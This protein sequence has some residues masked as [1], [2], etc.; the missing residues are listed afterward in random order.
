MQK[1]GDSTTEGESRASAATIAATPSGGIALWFPR[2]YCTDGVDWDALEEH[3]S[4]VPD[5]AFEVTSSSNSRSNSSL[6]NYE[7]KPGNV[8]A[9]HL[10]V[11]SCNPPAPLSFIQKLLDAN[12]D[13]LHQTEGSSGWNA[14]H[15][16][17]RFNREIDV[18]LVKLLI[19]AKPDL[20]T[21]VATAVEDFGLPPLAYAKSPEVVPMLIRAMP[22]NLVSS[23]LK[24]VF[25]KR[26]L[27]GGS[28]EA[29]EQ[30][31]RELSAIELQQGRSILASGIL[32]QKIARK[33]S[34][35]EYALYQVAKR[36]QGSDEWHDLLQLSSCIIRATYCLSFHKD[37]DDNA[38]NSSPPA[39]ECLTI[40][41]T[42]Q[43]IKRQALELYQ[44]LQQNQQKYRE[45]TDCMEPGH[46][47]LARPIDSSLGEPET[48]PTS[49]MP[50]H[51]RR[52]AAEVE[53]L[54]LVEEKKEEETKGLIVS[55]N[56]EKLLKCKQELD[57]KIDKSFDVLRQTAASLE[58]YKEMYTKTVDKLFE[59]AKAMSHRK[60]SPDQKLPAAVNTCSISSAAERTRV[61]L[62][63]LPPRLPTRSSSDSSLDRNRLL[64]EQSITEAIENMKAASQALD[65]Y[66]KTL[67][68]D[69]SSLVQEQQDQRRFDLTFFQ[70][71]QAEEAASAMEDIV[72]FQTQKSQLLA[73]LNQIKEDLRDANTLGD[74]KS[75]SVRRQDLNACWASCTKDLEL[76]NSKL[77]GLRAI[78]TKR[79]QEVARSVI[80]ARRVIRD[81]HGNSKSLR[82]KANRFLA[83]AK[84]DL[85]ALLQVLTADDTS[86]SSGGRQKATRRR[87]HRVRQ[88]QSRRSS[89][90]PSPAPL[91]LSDK[92]EDEELS[93]MTKR[94]RL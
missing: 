22:L 64:L 86:S 69:S 61:T 18:G 71:D 54:A 32:P 66:N 28:V 12:P 88:S 24:K 1:A 89:Q 52:F 93:R 16:A 19:D 27:V 50:A 75:Q 60:P 41:V 46:I 85:R 68:S 83:Y 13:A 10:A 78:I 59:E 40:L 70:S 80:W 30:I 21:E 48:I 57:T 47:L 45:N 38:I 15:C 82:R 84:K 92:V 42:Q 5:L 51:H 9:L 67:T 6:E 49:S 74:R 3:L 31:I 72:K 55:G 37:K 36:R 20:A 58:G 73:R 26:K 65:R 17:L 76:V 90:S 29:M 94:M 14:L 25:V 39:M 87:R 44:S 7:T 11:A 91:T 4:M 62:S 34:L 8:C 23:V 56:I 81:R 53:P 35:V 43:K 2:G 33:Q 77:D 63:A 79:R